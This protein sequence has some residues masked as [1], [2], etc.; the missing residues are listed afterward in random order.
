MVLTYLVYNKEEDLE[1]VYI[2][3]AA[4]YKDILNSEIQKA[5]SVTKFNTKSR[6]DNYVTELSIYKELNNYID[7]FFE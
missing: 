1:S 7:T 6:V 4:D 5:G 2:M 3:G